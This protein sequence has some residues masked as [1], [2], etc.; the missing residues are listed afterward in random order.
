LSAE[1]AVAVLALRGDPRL[2]DALR[3]L[4]DQDAEAE[5][6]VVNSGGGDAAGLVRDAGLDVPV[7]EREERL[8]PGGVRNL[9]IDA[10]AAPYIA[11]L[12]ADCLARRGWI[13]GRL[14]AHREGAGAVGSTLENAHAESSWANAAWLFH[15]HRLGPY[16]SPSR[17]LLY[18]LS[19]ERSVFDRHGCFR[20]DLLAGED[21]EFR[22][23][24]AGERVEWAPEVRTAHRYPTDRSA[25]LADARRRGGLAA[26][27]L[28][29]LRG[30]PHRLSIAVGAPAQA[31]RALAA[32]QRAPAAKR[33]DLRAAAPFVVPLAAAYA[34]GALSS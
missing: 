29:R 4:L 14:R 20:E 21:T 7:V 25:A 9:A 12:A 32:V 34:A 6:L 28:G 16:A 8:F 26:A 1:L 19:F 13:D 2:V 27:M 24:L 17:R 3:S 11:F 23:R 5:L 22:D 10:T 33:K 31:A 30:R 18:G 15:H